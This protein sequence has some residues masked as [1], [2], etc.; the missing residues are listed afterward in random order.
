[1]RPFFIHQSEFQSW[2]RFGSK[3]NLYLY[4]ER[5]YLDTLNGSDRHASSVQSRRR[6]PVLFVP[7]HCGSHRQVRSIASTVT[8][9]HAELIS[10]GSGDS[11]VDFDFFAIALNEEFTALHGH[12]LL[13]QAEYVN[14]AIRYI[15]SLYDDDDVS[16]GGDNTTTTTAT[17]TTD[18]RRPRSVMVIG[19]SMGGMVARTA[20]MLPKHLDGSVDTIITLSTPHNFPP[21]ALEQHI[22]DMYHEVNAFWRHGMA[23]NNS[24][25]AP[26][27]RDIALVSVVGG[28]LDG[29][30][31]SDFAYIGHVVPEPI[32]GMTVFTTGIP[33]VWLSANHHSILWCRQLVRRLSRAIIEL[34]YLGKTDVKHRMQVFRR[35][36]GSGFEVEAALGSPVAAIPGQRAKSSVR[37]I[38]LDKTG[39]IIRS[40][41]AAKRYLAVSG[42]DFAK[43]GLDSALVLLDVD[44]DR[45]HRDSD[46]R[47]IQIM[48]DPEISGGISQDDHESPHHS[49]QQ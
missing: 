37:A 47:C 36:F 25:R 8:Q 28:N 21:V 45:Y 29:M 12:S 7:G 22:Y 2:T 10:D 33:D 13:E 14:E 39:P 46:K 18:S 35:Y 32:N 17:T 23:L 11:L 42:H 5:G 30:I 27:L 6:V 43:L 44:Y 34:G 49:Q 19:H 24:H 3:Y 38:D 48:Y 16:S 26:D 9:M 15:L 1:M 41:H 40:R 31:N 20:F 4:R